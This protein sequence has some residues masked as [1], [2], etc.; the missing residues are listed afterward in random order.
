[1]LNE[2]LK[3]TVKKI[4][5]EGYDEEKVQKSLKQIL[6]RQVIS[7]NV[8]NSAVKLLNFIVNDMLDY[9]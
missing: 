1:M 4:E 5:E 9:A 7:T 8:Q 3:E 2:K 6:N